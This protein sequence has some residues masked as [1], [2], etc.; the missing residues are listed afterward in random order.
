MVKYTCTASSTPLSRREV[1]KLIV[2][3]QPVR[4]TNPITPLL[5][6]QLAE[7]KVDVEQHDLTQLLRLACTNNY[8]KDV[9]LSRGFRGLPIVGYIDDCEVKL[10]KWQIKA[11]EFARRIERSPPHKFLTSQ[12]GGVLCMQM[13]MGKTLTGITLALTSPR[14]SYE[15]EKYGANGYPTLV[16][17]S[18]TVMGEWKRSGFEK[19]FPKGVKVMY[20]H[21]MYMGNEINKVTISRIVQCDFVV[22]TYDV[23]LNTCRKRGVFLNEISVMGDI[24]SL[25]NGKVVYI[26]NRSRKQALRHSS[27]AGYGIIY[28]VPWERVICD[29]SQRFA[30]PDT[31][32]FRAVM[33]VYGRYKWC[34]TGTPIRNYITDIW[35]Q[36]RYCGYI[37]VLRKLDWKRRGMKKMKDDKLTEVILSMTCKGEGM[38]L[39]KKIIIDHKLELK[40]KPRE[41]YEKVQE[42]ARE[43]Y[44]KMMKG[45]VN[46][47]VVLAIFTR[48]RQVAVASYL[49]T[50]SSKRTCDLEKELFVFIQSCECDVRK[51][52]MKN[53]MKKDYAECAHL[54]KQCECKDAS[55]F[56]IR[57]PDRYRNDND[58][59][60]ISKLASTKLGFWLYDKE[61]SS[62]MDAMKIQKVIEVMR[63]VPNGEK[64]VVFSMFTSSLDLL[65]D[66]CERDY[67]ELSIIQVDG[68]VT[69]SQRSDALTLFRNSNTRAMFMTYKVGSEGLNIVESNNVICL[70][71]WWTNAVHRQAEARCWRMGQ[72]KDVT[73]HHIYAK[74]TIEERVISLCR[75]K[76]RLSDEMLKGTKSSTKLDKYTMGRLLGVRM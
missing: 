61:G 51:E 35:A 7:K 68:D 48:L 45:L 30:V 76:D 65:K 5:S 71:P 23:L 9:M 1:L 11:L 50:P 21:K 53:L 49:I 22:T 24:H 41:M 16:V 12:N 6:K 70:E 31:K 27:Q 2:T 67:P 36:L 60:N 20:F 55:S 32:T 73:V 58:Q 13:G 66:A 59:I 15:N 37:G 3:E 25:M 4:A 54:A 62:G 14:P 19:F 10:K 74:D 46:Y 43:M 29:E 18:K 28:G 56:R 57:L 52:M 40:G 69:G 44:E 8:I 72:M 39:P 34:L 75:D 38:K 64:V 42:C 47:A 33:A 17:T 63:A 26:N